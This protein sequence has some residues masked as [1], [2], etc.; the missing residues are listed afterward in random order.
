MNNGVLHDVLDRYAISTSSRKGKGRRMQ[1]FKA[2]TS[3][4]TRN[5][6]WVCNKNCTGRNSVFRKYQIVWS[7]MEVMTWKC[8]L[9]HLVTADY[10]VSASKSTFTS[11]R[12]L[13]CFVP[14]ILLP[15]CVWNVKQRICQH[16]KRN[17]LNK[18][19]F[20]NCVDAKTTAAALTC[21]FLLVIA[22]VSVELFATWHTVC[23][24]MSYFWMQ[25]TRKL[26]SI[27]HSD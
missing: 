7:V 16:K 15:M 27:E 8:C 12:N 3:Y 2:K 20:F 24:C 26:Q 19:W 1:L 21:I 18:N 10:C 5:W 6:L 23:V 14:R 17:A 4:L 13:E 25:G 22:S 9:E 11:C